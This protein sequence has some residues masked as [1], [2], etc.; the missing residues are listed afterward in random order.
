MKSLYSK[1]EPI[2]LLK[3]SY[4]ILWCIINFYFRVFFYFHLHVFFY[5]HVF[6]FTIKYLYSHLCY[7]SYSRYVFHTHDSY[8]RIIHNYC[9]TKISIR[10]KHSISLS[11]F[12]YRF[13]PFLY[14]ACT[15][16]VLTGLKVY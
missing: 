5:I 10:A 14:I 8:S 4:S 6:I 3:S 11:F 13:S 12:F 9:L 7:I 1:S 15:K 16:A 2:K